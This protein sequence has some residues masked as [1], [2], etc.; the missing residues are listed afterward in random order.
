MSI[1]L[2]EVKKFQRYSNFVVLFQ[3]EEICITTSSLGFCYNR[4]AIFFLSAFKVL[5]GDKAENFDLIQFKSKI[6]YKFVDKDLRFST[7]IR[8]RKSVMPNH[9]SPGHYSM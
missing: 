1:K 5:T 9:V 7:E 8:I 3:P 6:F 4:R 2:H